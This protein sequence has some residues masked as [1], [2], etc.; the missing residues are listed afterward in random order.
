MRADSPRN[1]SDEM[2]GYGC[3]RTYAELLGDSK[4]KDAMTLDGEAAT[5]RAN[6]AGKSAT[7]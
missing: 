7:S 3:A 1:G 4:G 5:D 6:K 2:A